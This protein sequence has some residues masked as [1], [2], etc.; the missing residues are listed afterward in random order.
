MW[1]KTIPYDE[2]TGDLKEAYDWQARSLGEPTEFT[3]LG[4]LAPD[5]VHARLQFYKASEN[6]PSDLTRVQ[7]SSISYL[8]SLLNGTEHCASQ[9]EL[10]LLKLE[11]SEDYVETLRER[12]FDELPEADA[13]MLRYCETLTL[14]PQ[15]VTLD[16]VERL[17]TV[18]FG[19]LEI[20]DINNMCANL[21][22]VNR[23]CKGLGLNTV[24]PRHFKAGATVPE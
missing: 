11:C 23:V 24:V 14:A 21:N 10:Q 20:L 3:R 19:D 13:A 12:R 1:I 9:A 2:A 5:I 17:R 16:D 15:D 22:Y 8:V 18:G 7:R 4:S 6:C